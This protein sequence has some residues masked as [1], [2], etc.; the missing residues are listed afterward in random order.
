MFCFTEKSEK[1]TVITLPDTMENNKVAKGKDGSNATN[2]S[3]RN[4]DQKLMTG[5]FIPFS[6]YNLGFNDINIVI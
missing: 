1:E 5:I 4:V 2:V 3:E 6:L